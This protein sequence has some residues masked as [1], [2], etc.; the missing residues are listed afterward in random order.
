M[1]AQELIENILNSGSVSNARDIGY[2][3]PAKKLARM[4]KASLTA[5]DR[6]DA[7]LRVPAAEYVPAIADTFTIIDITGQYLD[8][9]AGEE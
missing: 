3:E 2:L 1:T 8:Q 4:L 9:I 7:T 5:L 6:I